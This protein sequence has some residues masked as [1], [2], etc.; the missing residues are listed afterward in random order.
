MGWA[1]ASLIMN[2]VI[3]AVKPHVADKDARKEIYKPIFDAL[4]DGD[5]DTQDE[6]VGRDEAY[7]EIYSARFPDE[8][9]GD[10]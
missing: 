9:Y 5:W 1:S 4:E 3:D 7:D 2:S 6:C 10:D 8:D